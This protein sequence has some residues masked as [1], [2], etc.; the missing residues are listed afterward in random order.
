[1]LDP[2]SGGNDLVAMQLGEAY[3]VVKQVYDNL[4]V[5]QTLATSEAEI[6]AV[7][8]VSA[9]LASVIAIA[10]SVSLVAGNQDQV[11]AV[12][13]ALTDI[14]SVVGSLTDI[15][16]ILAALSTITSV[17]GALPNIAT[18]VANLGAI[19]A[20]PDSAASAAASAAAASGSATSAAAAQTAAEVARDTALATLDNFDDRY[21]GPKASD[22]TLDN[23]GNALAAGAIYYNTS[24]TAFYVWTGTAW[25]DMV[26]GTVTAVAALTLGTTGT[27]L[28]SSVANPTTT[29]VIT[30]NVPT[31]SAANR[32]A[33][34]PE[35]WATFNAKQDA[36]VSATNIKT[37]NGASI[38]GSGDLVVG[39][40]TVSKL[41]SD[42]TTTSTSAVDTGLS[43]TPAA[44][45]RYHVEVTLLVKTSTSST[46]FRFGVAWPTGLTSGAL[47]GG[48][49]TDTVDNAAGA[50]NTLRWHTFTSATTILTSAGNV[51]T[52]LRPVTLTGILDVGA[53]P[54][55]SLKIQ[56]A[57][58]AGAVTVTVAAGSNLRITAL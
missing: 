24:T 48:Y 7:A 52:A 8:A 37:I 55:G 12:A 2:N 23:D 14:T 40:G 31:A 11:A 26:G 39:G 51:G 30:L 22:P 38:L 44:N 15:S 41:T 21:L 27:D 50:T 13:A 25:D 3:L 28:S 16:D 19:T 6:A 10:E 54:T 35:D 34:S 4:D 45:T 56:V 42:F 33:L 32:G 17:A 49:N 1:M 58:G 47:D 29:P 18:T 9:D 5:I 20:A 53:S 36:L 57:T 46:N 43:F